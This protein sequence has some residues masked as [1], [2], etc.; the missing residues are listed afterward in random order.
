M[1]IKVLVAG[2]GKMAVNIGIYLLKRGAD[3]VWWSRSDS[4]LADLQATVEKK[5]K[6]LRLSDTNTGESTYLFSDSSNCPECSIL[7]ESTEEQLP[8][9]KSVVSAL[10]PLLSDNACI[11]SNSS[12]FLPSQIDGRCIGLHFFYPVEL[13]GCVE[14]IVPEQAEPGSRKVIDQLLEFLEIKPIIQNEISAFTINRLLLPLQ[15]ECFRM[16]RSGFS[17]ISVDEASNGPLLGGGQLT[18]MDNVG[19]DTIVISMRNYL[20]R[21]ERDIAAEISI[22]A[23]SIDYLVESGRL[24]RKNKFGLVVGA[25][26]P[27]PSKDGV[28]HSAGKL[29]S[30]FESLFINTCLK[31]IDDRIISPDDLDFALSSVFGAEVSLEKRIEQIGRVSMCETLDSLYARTNLSYFKPCSTLN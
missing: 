18:F 11:L 9:K 22:A 12:S 27:W 23:D 2:T 24:G 3:V 31:F 17:A 1:K 19:L 5:I 7:V 28:G 26:L 30:R 6:R 14:L 21:M 13:T 29:F 15:A 25:P 16:L 8:E 20:S 4:R 10:Y